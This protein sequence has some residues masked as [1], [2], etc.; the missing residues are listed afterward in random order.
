MITVNSPEA[1]VILEQYREYDAWRNAMK[2]NNAKKWRALGRD[3]S[4]L[5]SDEGNCERALLGST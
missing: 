3:T 4:R 2:I 5:V 1:D